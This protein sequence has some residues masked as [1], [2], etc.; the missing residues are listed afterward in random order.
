MNM[1]DITNALDAIKALPIA[2]LDKRQGMLI[3]LLVEMVNN[4]TSEGEGTELNKPLECQDWWHTLKELTADA[5][6]TRLGN[7]H[8]SAAYSHPML[9]KRVIKVG[10][11]K[12]DSGAAYIAFCRMHQGRAGIPN[13]YDVQRH[14]G[15]YTVVLDAL[16]E[17]ETWSND[18]HERYAEIARDVIEYNATCHNEYTG[19]DEEF[20][21]TCKLIRKFF[22]GIASFD[23]HSGNIMFDGMDTPFITDPVSFSQK[24][25]G[26]AFSIDPEELIKEVEAVAAQKVIDNAIERKMRH[27]ARLSLR[28]MKR[29]NRKAKARQNKHIAKIMFERRMK[30]NAEKRNEQRA[31]DFLGLQH[32]RNVWCN[33][34]AWDLAKLEL[35]V[36][37]AVAN[38]DHKAIVENRPLHIDRYLDKRFMG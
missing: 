1:T 13:V 20:V 35:K 36:A 5:G 14:A 26:G 29:K 12:E 7:G 4:E 31:Q 16:E 27:E 33:M 17:C 10:F 19:W 18:T 24:K 8:F 21:E 23:M 32:W 25:D 11:K 34:P 6:F 2:E 22:D 30:F 28:R 37:A 3:D 38:V 15:C 9:P